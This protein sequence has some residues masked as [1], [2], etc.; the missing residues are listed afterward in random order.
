MDVSSLNGMINI[1]P[2]RKL[3]HL[4]EDPENNDCN[5]EA[6]MDGKCYDNADLESQQEKL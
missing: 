5:E 4:S 6:R 1:K 3:L 2:D